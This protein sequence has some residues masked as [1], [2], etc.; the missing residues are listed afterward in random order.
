MEKRP[1]KIIVARYNEKLEWMRESPFNLFRYI[2][3]NKGVNDDFEKCNVDT[4]VN[5]PNV[6]RCDHT[7]LYHIVNNYNNLN[8]I[9]VFFPG[10]LNMEYKKNEAKQIL[11]NII[12]YRTGIFYGHPVKDIRKE[13]NTFTL[14][15]WSATE[16]A[17]KTLNPE[18]KTYPAKLR[19]YGKWYNY[20]FGKTQVSWFCLHGILSIHKLDIIQHD[21]SRYIQLLNAVSVHS[22]PEVGHYIERSWAA[23]F[24]PLTFTKIIKAH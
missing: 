13:F 4:I 1:V 2:V 5:L 9:N 6:G 8:D 21:V 23:I 20:M 3:Y 11:Y 10:S 18:S 16:S 22:N 19:P 14:D 17:N 24:H 12:K 15:N 7:Y